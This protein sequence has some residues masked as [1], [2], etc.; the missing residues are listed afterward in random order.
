MNQNVDVIVLGLGANGSSAIYHLSK[1]G[2]RVCGINQ[3]TPPHT[4]GSSHGQSRI[5][6]F[7]LDFV[8]ELSSIID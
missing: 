1:T 6:R 7:A 5:I 8:S 4:H 3:F 2:A